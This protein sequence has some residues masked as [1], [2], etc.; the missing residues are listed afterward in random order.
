[1]KTAKIVKSLSFLILITFLSLTTYSQ[2]NFIPGYIVT[3]QGDTLKGSIDYRNWDENPNKIA[4]KQDNE[5]SIH[6]Y[7]PLDIKS[8]QVSDEIYVSAI[9]KAS[10]NSRIISNLSDESNLEAKVDTTFLQTLVQGD[11]SLYHYKN[12]LGINN[13]YIKYHNKYILLIYNVYKLH[14]ENK[15]YRDKRYVGQLAFYFNNAPSIKELAPHTDYTKSSLSQLFLTYYKQNSQ[16]TKFNKKVDN[17]TVEFGI[18]AGTTITMAEFSGG[19]LFDYLTRVHIP[20]SVN[21]TAGLYLN[22]VIPRGQ[23]KLSIYNELIY[24][25][26]KAVAEYN[27]S[28]NATRTNS[29]LG[30]GYLSMNNMVRFKYPI[31]R[32]FVFINGG[33]TTGLKISETNQKI[34]TSTYKNTKEKAL[35]EVRKLEFGYIGGVGLKYHR[36][37]LEARYKRTG[38]SSPYVFLNS[39]VGQYFFVLGYRF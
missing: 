19:D 26:Y 18:V 35:D 6:K 30:F 14:S 12:R 27:S 21:P 37:S 38:G 9:V 8:F 29:E 20:K 15:I 31:S 4:F 2:Q 24:C 11:K 17:G 33:I 34:V 7:T 1:M 39:P 5:P 10:V 25:S 23:G 28:I 13:F 22:Y 32:C 16:T 36:Y 3:L